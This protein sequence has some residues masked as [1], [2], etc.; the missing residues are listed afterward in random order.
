MA[1]TGGGAQWAVCG[2]GAS[3]E[4]ACGVLTIGQKLM[5][6][7]P[8]GSCFSDCLLPRANE[9]GYSHAESKRAASSVYMEQAWP[10][11]WWEGQGTEQGH[12]V[13]LRSLWF[14]LDKH[15]SPDPGP[16]LRLTSITP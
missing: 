14:F 1:L 16:R 10:R 13:I 11:P 5:A 6:E 15:K 7:L 3:Q 9:Q 8:V 12:L 4:M 2:E